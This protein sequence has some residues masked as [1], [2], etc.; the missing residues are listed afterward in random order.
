MR[1]PRMFRPVAATALALGLFLTLSG[2]TNKP[3]T[4]KKDE[5]KSEPALN[6]NPT[7]APNPNTTL[8]TDPVI[9]PPPKKIDGSIEQEAVNFLKVLTHGVV[10]ADQL[11]A[12][13][14]KAIGL[15]AELPADKAKGYSPDAAE[16]WL[17]RIGPRRSFGIA[18]SSKLLGNVALFRGSLIGEGP[19][20]YWLRMVQE[21]GA[22]KV[23]W[24]SMTSVRIAELEGQAL[25]NPNGDSLCQE[26]AATA[27][28]GLLVDKD[29]LAREDR[30]A[31]LAAG[32]TPELKKK[33]A[34]PLDSDKKDGFD[35][36][37][38]LLSQ[39]TAE[40]TGDVLFFSVT[41]HGNTPD[42]QVV[43]TRGT[44]AKSTY[45]MKLAKGPGPC[46]WLVDDMIK[47]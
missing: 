28:A 30:T 42:F 37:R 40:F 38:G 25:S 16:S 41:Q 17:R 10:R 39:K 33:W 46:Q 11:T 36:N 8:P 9:P 43:I 29:A 15:P 21:G 13:F 7:P 45:L 31:I 1:A 26:F 27:V 4:D 14:V 18:T 2:C 35:Y 19:G 3:S 12:G 24:F 22:W 34:E 44:G 47:Q 5:K 20:G 6:I 32:L 23:D